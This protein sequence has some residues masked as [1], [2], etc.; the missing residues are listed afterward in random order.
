M[1]VLIYYKKPAKKGGDKKNHQIAIVASTA[2]IKPTM[3][4]G[5]A[6]S[7]LKTTAAVTPPQMPTVPSP[8]PR[9]SMC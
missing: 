5:I 4:T 8:L 6:A 7:P 2:Q 9:S 1:G 3:L